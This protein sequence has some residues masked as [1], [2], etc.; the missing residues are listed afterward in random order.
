VQTAV[1]AGTYCTGDIKVAAAAS[2]GKQVYS[3]TATGSGRNNMTINTGVTLS[4]SDVFIMSPSSP[5]GGGDAYLYSFVVG[6]IKNA[7]KNMVAS[8]SI[9]EFDGDWGNC[10]RQGAVSYSGQSVSLNS[11]SSYIQFPA[12]INYTWYLIKG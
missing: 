6:A 12:E 5:Y 1:S 7:S 9:E 3:G 8:I 4:N 10:I 11:G 2:S